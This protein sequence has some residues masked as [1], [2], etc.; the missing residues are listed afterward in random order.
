M[1]FPTV[2]TLPNS[3]GSKEETVITTE[4]IYGGHFASNIMTWTFVGI[5][6]SAFLKH[7]ICAKNLSMVGEGS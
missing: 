7:V 4:S 2:S 3:L 6:K 1:M 5:S